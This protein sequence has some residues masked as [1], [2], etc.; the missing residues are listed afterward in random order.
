MYTLAQQQNLTSLF[1]LCREVIPY[2]DG[3]L[4]VI[5]DS[6]LTSINWLLG[7]Q[8][9]RL[10]I[11][12]LTQDLQQHYP[13]AG[14]AYYMTRTWELLCWQPMYITFI[15]IYGLKQLPD[16]THFK[17]KHQHNSIHGFS[18][19]IHSFTSADTEQLIQ[20]ASHQLSTLL[21]HYRTQLDSLIP[22]RKSYTQRLTADLILSIM[23]KLPHFINDFNHQDMI[24]HVQIWLKA[25]ELPQ[26]LTDRI[27]IDD[28]QLI[29][30]IRSTCCLTYKINNAICSNCP[31]AQRLNKKTRNDN[32]EK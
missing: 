14:S 25:M 9:D 13:T 10:T 24:R 30:H 17:Q 5:N 21:E 7:N 18:F 6:P 29:T 8:Q 3:K 16:L 31:K 26:H 11:E 27:L 28:Q 23:T 4:D 15:A 20:L 19:N 32:N 12:A 22:C 1:N 2:L